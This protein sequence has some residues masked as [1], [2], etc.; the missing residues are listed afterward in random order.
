MS[1]SYRRSQHLLK[2]EI[3]FIVLGCSEK[4]VVDADQVMHDVEL[5]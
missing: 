2:N 3:L 5:E 4:R 1:N